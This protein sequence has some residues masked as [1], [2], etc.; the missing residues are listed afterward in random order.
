MFAQA[1][2][3]GKTIPL[4][5]LNAAFTDP[6]LINLA[7]YEAS[8]LAEHISATYGQAAMNKLLRT[9]GGGVEGEEAL[10]QGLGIGTEQL[11]GSFSASINK[12]YK[13]LMDALA[14]PPGFEAAVTDPAK[15]ADLAKAYPNSYLAQ[16]ALGEVQHQAGDLD[17]AMATLSK[18]ATLVPAATGKESPHAIMAEIAIA[19]KNPVRATT[20]LEALLAHDDSNVDAARQLV[21]LLGEDADPARL[22]AAYEN[23]VAMDPFDPAAHAALGKLLLERRT[24]DK[25]IRELRAAL[26][27]KPAD[28]AAVHCDLAE[29]YMA[30]NQPDQAKRQTLA[31]LEIAPSYERAQNLLLKLVE[32]PQ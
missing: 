25:A 14:P 12:T 17:G 4:K 27:S 10:E 29:A 9:Y 5:D 15:L 11:Q 7:Y 26:A 18:A 30:V 24:Y 31:A 3:R 32:A 21:S 6:Q 2:Q 22:T 23:L 28:P 1:L 19:Q 13:P 16:L 20:E 8:L